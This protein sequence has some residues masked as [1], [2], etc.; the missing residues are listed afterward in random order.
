MKPEY[1]R[2]MSV[3]VKKCKINVGYKNN[4]LVFPFR[5]ISY[6]T[7][8]W[9]YFMTLEPSQLYVKDIGRREQSE[10]LTPSA[11]TNRLKTF[12]DSRHK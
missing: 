7:L 4:V 12:V 8:A 2:E 10:A 11:K 5:K 1:I 3:Y 6:K 9:N